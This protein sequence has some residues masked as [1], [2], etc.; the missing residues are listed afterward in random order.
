MAEK[1]YLDEG[2]YLGETRNGLPHGRGTLTFAD[3]RSYSGEIDY[4]AQR[5]KGV[6]RYP[7]GSRLWGGFTIC[8]ETHTW[9]YTTACGVSLFGAV[10]R[11]VSEG[12]G[13][14]RDSEA[15]EICAR[16]VELLEAREQGI[17]YNA[18]ALLVDLALCRGLEAE[19]A[20][21]LL[22][23][24]AAYILPPHVLNAYLS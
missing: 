15:D 5:G 22:P 24:D 1:L 20:V 9:V 3:G 2:E 7:D 12:D 4:E 6:W 11:F 8:S 19:A 10:R 17:E 16:M 14:E 18:R 23:E 13:A 21:A